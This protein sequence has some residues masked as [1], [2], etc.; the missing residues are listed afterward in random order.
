MILP[1]AAL[2]WAI[3]PVAL[4]LM[5]RVIHVNAVLYEETGRPRLATIPATVTL[6]PDEKRSV[7]KAALRGMLDENPTQVAALL[8]LAREFEADGDIA[9]ASRAYRTAL[10]LA[11]YAREVLVFSANHFVQQGDRLGVELL[12]RIAAHF[13]GMQKQVFPVLAQILAS[14]KQRAVLA[15]VI[16]RNPTWIGPFLVDACTRGVEPGVLMSVLLKSSRSAVTGTA[17]AACLIDRLRALGRWGQAYDFWLNLLPRERRSNVGFV[18]NGSFEFAPSGAGFDW[19]LQQSPAREAGHVAEIVQA[20]NVAGRQA[21][22]ITYNGKRQVG[23]P[24]RQYLFLSSGQYL[25][26]GLVRTEAIKA[27]R[28]V[29]WTLRCMDRTRILKTVAASERFLGSGEWRTFATEFSVDPSCAGQ[30][31][32]LEPITAEGSAVFVS[33]IAWFDD[34]KIKK[35]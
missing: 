3:V 16:S 17:E 34:M 21:L 13:P 28:G 10:E 6:A 1:T 14:G 35:R 26:T 25:L 31:L 8:M 32:Q 2:R 23:L 12:A 5:W 15:E 29:Q 9:L 20:P 18:F 24:V 30:V 33:G 19:S 22:R 7:E 27:L 4:F 11:P